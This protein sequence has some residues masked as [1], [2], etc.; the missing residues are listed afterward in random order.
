[1]NK[2]DSVNM[3]AYIGDYEGA[4]HSPFRWST[5]HLECPLC[6]HGGRHRAHQIPIFKAS[7]LVKCRDTIIYT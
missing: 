3:Q 1:M 6:M 7:F 5:V 4:R 2:E